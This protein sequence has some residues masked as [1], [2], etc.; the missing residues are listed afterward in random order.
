MIENRSVSVI[1]PSYQASTY[2]GCAIGSVLNQNNVNLELIIVDDCSTDAD[3][4]KILVQNYNDPRINLIL[5]TRKTNGAEC[6]NIG[7]ELAKFDIIA[8]LD[9]DDVWD[10]NKLQEQIKCLSENSLIS[11]ESVVYSDRREIEYRYLDGTY[12]HVDIQKRLFNSVYPKLFL[13]TSTLMFRKSEVGARPFDSNLLRHQD[14]QFI[15]HCADKGMQAKVLRSSLNAYFYKPGSIKTKSWNIDVSEQFFDKYLRKLSLS[16]R[17]NF[18]I[19]NL[20]VH[21]LRTGLGI[22]WI[23]LCWRKK[24]INILFLIKC[25][26][27]LFHL[28]NR[29][30]KR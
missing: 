3:E 26:A 28:L 25:L 21:A 15:L 8:L 14:Y 16:Q 4:L 17:Q 20:M 19:G 24:T 1:I 7:I 5:N 30:I 13:Q 22:K 27:L 10:A 2:I 6:R 23:S 18:L 11:C 9:A 29:K 12:E